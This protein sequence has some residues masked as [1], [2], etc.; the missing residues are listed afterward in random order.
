LGASIPI[1]AHTTLNLG[2]TFYH[3]EDDVIPGNPDEDFFTGSAGVT[4]AF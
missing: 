4:I 2:A 3:T 1:C